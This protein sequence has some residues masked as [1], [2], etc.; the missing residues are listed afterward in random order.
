MHGLLL[1]C[2]SKIAQGVYQALPRGLLTSI[3]CLGGFP[4]PCAARMWDTTCLL[5]LG[6]LTAA[7]GARWLLL[8]MPQRDDVLH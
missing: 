3:C 7:A 4:A 1:W 5:R 8:S 6:T 2:L